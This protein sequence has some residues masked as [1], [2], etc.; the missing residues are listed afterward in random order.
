MPSAG[1]VGAVQGLKVCGAGLGLRVLEFRVLAF[2]VQLSR[3]LGFRTSGF[4]V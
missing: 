2:W 3:G 4:G 1:V